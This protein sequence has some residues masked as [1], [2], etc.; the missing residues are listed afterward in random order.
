MMLSVSG[1]LLQYR[2]MENQRNKAEFEIIKQ[3]VRYYKDKNTDLPH[4][5]ELLWQ[6]FDYPVD[7]YYKLEGVS[8]RLPSALYD[9]TSDDSSKK[10]IRRAFVE[11]CKYEPLLRKILLMVDPQE[12]H[13]GYVDKKGL[14]WVLRKL[15]LEGNINFN[16]EAAQASRTYDQ[17]DYHMFIT[18]D[19]RNTESHQ[20]ESW[21]DSVLTANTESIY[22]LYLTAIER[23]LAPLEECLMQVRCE[24]HE[25]YLQQLEAGFMDMATRY[26][27]LSSAE[28]LAVFDG[29]VSEKTDDDEDSGRKGTVEHIR[30]HALPENRMLIWA[31]AGMGKTTTLNYL[32]YKDAVDLRNGTINA[33]P[34][35]VPL[36]ILI[37]DADSIIDYACQTTGIDRTVME[38]MLANGKVH[39]FLDA[40]NETQQRLLSARRTEIQTLLDRYPLTQIIIT[41]RPERVS[42][43]AGVPVF[44]LQKMDEDVLKEFIEKNAGDPAV[45]SAVINQIDNAGYLKEIIAT[46]LMATRCLEIAR[47]Y[48]QIPSNEGMI[49]GQ[50][51]KAVMQREIAE[52]KDI[53]MDEEKLGCLLAG[54]ALYGLNKYGTNSGMTRGEV[55][56]SFDQTMKHFHFE[57]DSFYALDATNKLGIITTDPITSGIAFSHQIYQDYYYARALDLFGLQPQYLTVKNSEDAQYEQSTIY[58]VH[59]SEPAQQK[60][61]LEVLSENAL[62]TAAKTVASGDFPSDYKDIITGQAGVMMAAEDFS[63]RLRAVTALA[64]IREDEAALE[65]MM[66][67]LHQLDE[68]GNKISLRRAR[69]LLHICVPQLSGL[70]QMKL[71]QLMI[72]DHLAVKFMVPFIVSAETDSRVHKWNEEDYKLITG[73]LKYINTH[74]FTKYAARFCLAMNVPKACFVRQERM[75]V[76]LIKTQAQMDVIMEYLKRYDL[77]YDDEALKSMF[78]SKALSS[79][80]RYSLQTLLAMENFLSREAFLQLFKAGIEKGNPYMHDYVVLC[81]D[82]PDGKEMRLNEKQKGHLEGIEPVLTDEEARSILATVTE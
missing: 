5:F 41:E 54:L 21:T 16:D 50:F 60:E 18:Y 23:N 6:I 48:G 78:F 31:D 34:V 40:V 32:A 33:L 28:D 7:P 69:A 27:H 17:F 51:L 14:A 77:P 43:F 76:F 59:N 82:K 61:E 30:R 52:K 47:V 35:C 67:L 72:K 36:G 57:Y 19:L 26:V 81:L 80:K 11:L 56:E 74:F 3:T 37:N 44:R 22:I 63:D 58:H 9:I 53:R 42:S 24:D 65:G 66:Q 45:S 29:F 38:R 8:D 10:T 55:L 75:S 68:E 64:M 25:E 12:Y 15:H 46:P 4:L 71:A 20:L 73:N 62:L 70:S 49:I 79:K 1:L 13:Q 39:L 2:R